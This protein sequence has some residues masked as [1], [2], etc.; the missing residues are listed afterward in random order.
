[1]RILTSPMKAFLLARAAQTQRSLDIAVPIIAP[2]SLRELLGA[3]TPRLA[4]G[5]RLRLITHLRG[6]A[7]IQGYADLETFRALG[8]TVRSLPALH[9]KVYLFDGGSAL[10]STA[11]LTRSGLEANLELGA[12]VEDPAL[13]QQLVALFQGWWKAASPV[14]LTRLETLVKELQPSTAAA[15]S[16]AG[17]ELSALSQAITALGVTVPPG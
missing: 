12:F 8:Q 10:I 11:N 3:F 6:E 4:Q 5:A 13:V 15:D 16:A 7:F 17:R 9:A 14:D 2:S 1:M